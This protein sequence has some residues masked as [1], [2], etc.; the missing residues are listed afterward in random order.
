MWY[1]IV[2]YIETVLI[3]EDIYW[4]IYDFNEKLSRLYFKIILWGGEEVEH[5]TNWLHLCW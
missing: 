4:N 5:K 3:F 1:S 2:D